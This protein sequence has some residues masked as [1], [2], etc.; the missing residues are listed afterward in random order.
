M[1][2]KPVSHKIGTKTTRINL[3]LNR[4]MHNNVLVVN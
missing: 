2:Q 3:E 1:K 4:Q